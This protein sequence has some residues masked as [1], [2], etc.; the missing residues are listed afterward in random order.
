MA[1]WRRATPHSS[2]DSGFITEGTHDLSLGLLFWPM[3]ADGS[4]ADM[5]PMGLLEPGFWET[6]KAEK[7]FPSLHRRW[8]FH[9]ESHNTHLC[10]HSGSSG[11]PNTSIGFHWEPHRVH[12]DRIGM[13]AFHIWQPGP[14]PTQRYG[15]DL[16]VASS[17]S[18]SPRQG[19]GAASHNAFSSP[20]LPI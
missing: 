3:L 1:A 18:P 13:P 12:S 8:S 16:V 15:P 6:L 4:E 10:R 19:C 7:A 9:S 17:A 5:A 14:P 2:L 20:N 11:I